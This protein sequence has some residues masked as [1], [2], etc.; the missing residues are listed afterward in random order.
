[1]K[2]EYNEQQEQRTEE[3]DEITDND[4]DKLKDHIP[5][6]DIKEIDLDDEP[7]AKEPEEQDKNNTSEPKKTSLGDIV[8]APYALKL[9]NIAIPPLAVKGYKAAGY[10]IN[11]SDYELNKSEINVLSE[12]LQNYLNYIKIDLKNPL[13]AFLLA[14]SIVY[15]SKAVEVSE[16][17]LK[18]RKTS[19][20]SSPT[21][22]FVP[23]E[24][25][26]QEKLDSMSKK[27]DWEKDYPE[28]KQA[29]IRATM[30]RRNRGVNEAIEWLSKKGEL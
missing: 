9:I 29:L 14:L 30:K 23:D 17:M 25:S 6:G 3:L 5:D 4:F 28:G 7:E 12:P 11:K 24:Q 26:I 16:T 13:Y 27:V 18:V 20:N 21:D 8:K 10:K 22:T 15:G 19:K 1:M 2:Q